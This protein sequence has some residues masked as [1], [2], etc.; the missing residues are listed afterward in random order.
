MYLS[1][2]SSQGAVKLVNA[3][4]NAGKI[5]LVCSEILGIYKDYECKEDH[6]RKHLYERLILVKRI[7]YVLLQIYFIWTVALVTVPI[8]YQLVLKKRIEV[9][10]LLIPGVPTDTEWGITVHQMFHSMCTCL[11]SFG[12]FASDTMC[13]VIV[14]HIPLIKNIIKS[15]FYDLDV[16]LSQ[17]PGERHRSQVLLRDILQCHQR[18]I[19]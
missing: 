7:M 6:Y 19:R 16:T 4:Y 12:N 1:Y 3:I 9:F 13:F 17:Y 15:K 10:H 8:F 11:G 2:F 14:A 5:R 18:Y